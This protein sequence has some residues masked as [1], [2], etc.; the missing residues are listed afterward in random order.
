MLAAAIECARHELPVY[1]AKPRGKS[2]LHKGWQRSA[3]TKTDYL[4]EVW[5]RTPKANVGVACRGLTVLD[6][7][8][9][10]GVDAIEELGLPPTATVRTARGIHCYFLGNAP[11]VAGVLPDVEV[12]GKGSGVLA[13]GSIHPN[14]H[15]YVWEIPPWEVPP[16]G[17]PDVIRHL[18]DEKRGSSTPGETPGYIYEGGRHVFLLR[19]AGS[20]RGRFGVDDLEPVLLAVNDVQCLQPVP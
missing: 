17:I 12:R 1:A 20:F 13:P 4:A 15:E 10:R 8:S 11:T 6:A 16:I 5:S 14:G 18:I 2:P 19:M 9:S 3:T 7:D